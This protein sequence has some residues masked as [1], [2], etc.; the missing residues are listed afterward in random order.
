V[1]YDT[2]RWDFSLL[3]FVV[4]MAIYLAPTV[5]ALAIRSRN[6]GAVA[7]VNVLTGWT[8]IGWIVSWVLCFTGRRAPSPGAFA[9]GHSGPGGLSP[10]GLYW[11]DGSAWRDTR[12][13][14]PPAAP[15]SPDG[16]WWWDGRAWRPVPS[17]P[18][19]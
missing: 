7:A 12:L 13:I 1:H 14:A 11:W 5:T 9:P 2:F 4:F 8:V 15:R 3:S 10:D 17:P 19:G 18:P 16:H 6:A